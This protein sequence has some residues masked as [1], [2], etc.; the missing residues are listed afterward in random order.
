MSIYLSSLSNTNQQCCTLTLKVGLDHHAVYSRH[1]ADRTA[2][3]SQVTKKP[4]P[5]R[6]HRRV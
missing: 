4:T 3:P 2:Y 6:A 5:V 1:A